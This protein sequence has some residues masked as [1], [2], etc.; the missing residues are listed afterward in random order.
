MDAKTSNRGDDY[1]VRPTI[2]RKVLHPE[3][4]P[5]ERRALLLR[6]V[7]LFNQGEHFAAHEAWEEVWRST[8]PEPKPLF[9]GLI[10]AA[11]AL[12]QIL[13]LGRERGPRGTLSKALRNLESFRPRACGFELEELCGQLESWLLWLE[14]GGEQP[15]IPA[16]R[17]VDP[18]I[19]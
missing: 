11:A 1:S 10:Q 4:S 16:L 7:E 15:P 9:Q 3:L 13:D 5:G 19:R 12:H 2:P 14:E 18:E 8:N 6:G 17:V